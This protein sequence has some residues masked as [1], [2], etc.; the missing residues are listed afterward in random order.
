MILLKNETPVVLFYF[1]E[2]PWQGLHKNKSKN[3]S[4]VVPVNL[5]PI[6]LQ[7]LQIKGIEVT[8]HSR[9]DAYIVVVLSEEQR[10]G[11]KP[12]IEKFNLV[13]SQVFSFEQADKEHHYKLSFL[14]E[15]AIEILNYA[16][17]KDEHL[18]RNYFGDSVYDVKV[19]ISCNNNCLHCVIKPTV[20]QIKEISPD[21][22]ILNSG[23]GMWHV[24]DSSFE[25]IIKRISSKKNISAFVLTGGEPTIRKDFIAILKWLYYNR[26]TS[27]ISIQTNGR[28][29]ADE[30]LIKA[31][32]RYSGK[33]NFAV[34]IHGMEKTHN[35]IVNNRIDSGNPF[36]ETVQG[37]K[38]L[39]AYF[40][41]EETVRTEIVISN[42][43]KDELVEMVRFQHEELGINVI[44]M[45]YP[46]LCDFSK[47]DIIKIA[48]PLKDLIPSFKKIN[49][50]IKN[51]P[52]LTVMTE[53]VPPCVYHKFDEEIYFQLF[54]LSKKSV[55]LCG[56]GGN[57]I[58]NFHSTWLNDH[59]KAL[60]CQK[61]VLCNLCPGV[62][63]ESLYLN[64]EHLIPINLMTKHI[65]ALIRKTEGC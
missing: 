55:S 8:S 21:K 18:L 44:G 26:P 62:W 1:Q 5:F 4:E 34:A 56:F 12:L 59:A 30:K 20:M 61:C 15:D 54:R 7:S 48:P 50:Y 29:L 41:N 33:V 32:L 31:I 45:S 28:R 47:E 16:I 27:K 51:N 53:E 52:C 40:P 9:E 14:S 57:I 58:D 60:A 42:K 39:L 64:E 2:K 63:K 35:E 6:L 49:E 38:H 11:L 46:H 24:E 13:Y 23:Y 43:N 65:E 3:K 37:I 22:V 19:G 17:M 10:D 25:E 36:I